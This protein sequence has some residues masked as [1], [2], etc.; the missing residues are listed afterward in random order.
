MKKL[1]DY[2]PE[3]VEGKNIL[4][5]GGTT[6]IGRAAAVMLASLGANVLIF[7]RHQEELN[8][9]LKDLKKTGNKHF[10]GMIA[11]V[12]DRKHVENVFQTFD[13]EFGDI[14]VLINNA[15]LSF[16]SVM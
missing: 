9:A 15:A 3:S 11:D 5:T 12:S 8:D 6:G 14:D 13:E 2:L 4:I 7:G 16:G 10:T 1:E